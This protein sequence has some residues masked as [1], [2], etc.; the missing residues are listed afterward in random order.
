MLLAGV[1]GLELQE[2]LENGESK[3][4][5]ALLDEKKYVLTVDFALKVR[6]SC[7]SLML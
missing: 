3:K 2:K 4:Y 6:E 1:F 7:K 5:L